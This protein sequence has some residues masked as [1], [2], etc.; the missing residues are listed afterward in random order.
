MHQRQSLSMIHTLVL[1]GSFPSQADSECQPRKLFGSGSAALTVPAKAPQSL[2]DNKWFLMMSGGRQRS[3]G[4][5]RQCWYANLLA[6][7]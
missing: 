5:S 3:R 2:A 7:G 6:E 1:I 4:L